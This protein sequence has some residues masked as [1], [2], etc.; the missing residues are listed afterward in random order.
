[1]SSS[2]SRLVGHTRSHH[3]TITWHRA[4]ELGISRPEITSWTDAGR[5]VHP[6]PGVYAVAGA[7]ATWRQ[8]V[9]IAAGSSAGWASHRAAAAL[10]RLDGFPPRQVEVL[11]PYGLGRKRSD[12]IVHESRAIRGVDLDEVDGIPC[13]SVVRTV[14]DLAAVA[15]P[16]LVAQALD[17]ASRRWPGTLD[18]VD[19]RHA[20]LA[21]RGR[22]GTRLMRAL[23]DKRL[24]RDRYT[25]SE[26]ETK[27]VSLVRSVGL[28]EPVLQHTVRDGRFVAHLD[29]AWPPIMW[30]VECDSLEHHLSERAHNWDRQRRRHLKRLGWDLA[31]VT[32]DDVTKHREET[33]RE[34]LDLYRARERSV[35]VSAQSPDPT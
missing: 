29:L 25:D 9:S 32:Y 31:E 15:H 34:L 5:L 6:A 22:R 28:P 8:R 24:G 16:F 23:L 12:W 33:G 17:H 26:F 11:V 10:W 14:L 18:A 35:S 21:R 27:T 7:P 13:T 20:E 1:M 4:H 19:R 30:A 3:A 2:W